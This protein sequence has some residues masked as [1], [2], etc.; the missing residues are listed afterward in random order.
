MEGNWEY[1]EYSVAGSR[2]GVA[3]QIGGWAEG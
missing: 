3:L 2:H 1:I